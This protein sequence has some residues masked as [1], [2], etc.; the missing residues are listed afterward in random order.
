MVGVADDGILD[1]LRKIVFHK[2]VLL[3]SKSETFLW[4]CCCQ[5][6][7]LAKNSES[8]KISF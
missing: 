3:D 2:D 4:N 1:A 7:Y 5:V 8:S 6:K